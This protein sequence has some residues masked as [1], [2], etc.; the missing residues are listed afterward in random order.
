MR[1][2]ADQELRSGGPGAGRRGGAG[3]GA[4]AG[5]GGGSAYP[6]AVDRLMAGLTG[7]PGIGRRSAERLAFHILKASEEEALSLA[8]AIVDVK[9]QVRHCGVCASLS[10]GAVCGVCA[11]EGRDRGTVLVVEQ[12]KDLIAIEQTG[13]YRGLYH[14]L[15]GRLSPLDGIGPGELTVGQ[16]LQRVEEPGRNAGGVAVREVILGLN[17]T[18]EGDGTAMYLREELS[19]RGVVLSRLARGLPTGSHLEFVSRAVLM[20]ALEGRQRV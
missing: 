20:D 4:A 13:R 19:R 17:P 14:V 10:D 12:P 5:G 16:L 9:Q 6:E 2:D 18:L 1:N 11:D 3:G 8:R 7:L 15:M